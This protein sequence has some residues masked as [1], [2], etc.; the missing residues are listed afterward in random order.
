MQRSERSGKV[1]LHSCFEFSIFRVQ[2]STRRSAFE[3][4]LDGIISDKAN[5]HFFYR[6]RDIE[7]ILTLRITQIE[8]HLSL[9]SVFTI[10]N[11][12]NGYQLCSFLCSGYQGAFPL[13]KR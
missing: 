7:R 13:V 1:G 9:T 5:N 12:Q 3:Q 4:M 6:H 11:R 8:F 10:T 2:I